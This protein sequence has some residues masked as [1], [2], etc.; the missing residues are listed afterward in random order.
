MRVIHAI[1]L[2]GFLYQHGQSES[3]SPEDDSANGTETTSEN[4]KVVTITAT[5]VGSLATENNSMITSQ[6]SSPSQTTVTSSGGT[7]P[8]STTDV[9]SSTRISTMPTSPQQVTKTSQSSSTLF[10][11]ST[12]TQS[13]V[14]TT[15]AM[16]HTAVQPVS[17]STT[18][19]T[20]GVS[21]KPSPTTET[22]VHITQK[23]SA[24][25]SGSMSQPVVTSSTSATKSTA[26]APGTNRT[27]TTAVQ[28]S[29]KPFSMTFSTEDNRGEDGREKDLYQICQELMKNM[30]K[31]NCTLQGHYGENKKIIFEGA[32]IHVSPAYL[33]EYYNDLKRP[34]PDNSTLT[35][36]LGS[37]SALLG[38]I[39]FLTTYTVC[40]L[41]AKRKDQ[42]HLTEELQTV[43]NGYHDNPTLEVLEVQ[44]EMQEKSALSAELSDSW[45]V[46]GNSLAKEDMADEEDTHL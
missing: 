12:V 25:T 26:I 15:T 5:P 1:I 42:Q 3:T 28:S 39:I 43:E 9:R 13:P 46:P 23:H 33:E 29:Q 35:I 34:T 22:T 8:S 7:E 38:V 27:G 16:E 30:Q 17:S 21:S 19:A 32:V 24:S 20:T 10:T 45:I 11:P 37:C 6:G 18:A 4:N 44:S 41:K 31:A 2:L 40:R 14:Q 36:I